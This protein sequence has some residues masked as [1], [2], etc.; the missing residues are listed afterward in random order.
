MTTTPVRIKDISPRLGFQAHPAVDTDTKV[1]LVNEL[2]A[3]GVPAIEVSS[4]VRP[5]LIPGLADADEVFARVD[6]RPGVSLECCVGNLRGLERAIDAGA[7]AAWFLLSADE[8]FARNNIGRT[9]R[10][11]LDELERMQER[12]SSASITLGTYLIFAWGGPTSRPRTPDDLTTLTDPLM[13][14]GVSKWILADS[15]GYAAPHQMR[16]T[17]SYALSLVE[18]DDITVQIHDDR[19]L[20]LANVLELISLGVKNIDAALAGSGGH[21]A[22][23]T[24]RGAGMCTEDLVQL[25][26]LQGHETGIDLTSLITTANWLV[27]TVGIP[28]RGFTRAVGA[29]PSADGPTPQSARFSWH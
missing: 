28:G 12:A 23:L 17:V 19:G 10:Q 11:S 24:G 14:M 7:D 8:D 20:G 29:V 16:E 3:A 9:M 21:P 18:P 1:R 27:D 26:E 6:R 22:I 25:L 15:S 2:I 13:S 4:F 5:D